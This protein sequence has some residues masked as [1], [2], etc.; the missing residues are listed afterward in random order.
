[1]TR[2]CVNI[3]IPFATVSGTIGH[4]CWREK[5]IDHR[6]MGISIFCKETQ[7]LIIYLYY[8]VSVDMCEYMQ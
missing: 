8:A 6:S 3:V 1:M 5:N 2:R 4:V 7:L